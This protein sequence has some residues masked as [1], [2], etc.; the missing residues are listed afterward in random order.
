MTYSYTDSLSFAPAIQLTTSANI[1]QTEIIGLNNGVLA[2]DMTF[3]SAFDSLSVV[4]GI[5][6]VKAALLA[7]GDITSEPTLL[8]NLSITKSALSSLYMVGPAMRMITYGITTTFGPE[9]VTHRL[10][11][12]T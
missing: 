4:S 5:R 1:F 10:E 8:S 7:L 3:N 12:A 11:W 2:Y 6:I 9:I